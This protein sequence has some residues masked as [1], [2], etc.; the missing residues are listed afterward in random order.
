MGQ[1]FSFRLRSFFPRATSL[2]Y[3]V[4]RTLVETLTGDLDTM[5][6][7]KITCPWRDS[8]DSLAVLSVTSLYHYATLGMCSGR[9]FVTCGGKKSYV[10]LTLVISATS[11]HCRLGK[12]RY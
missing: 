4:K 12:H 8:K 3:H 11:S 7:I 10:I 2:R 9:K 6:T 1:V 5:E